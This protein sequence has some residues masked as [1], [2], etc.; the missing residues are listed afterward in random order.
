MIELTF[1]GAMGCVG[2]SAVLVDTGNEKLM[3]DYGV[4]VSERPHVFPLPVEG[5]VD[6]ILLTHS[7]LDHS[8]ALPILSRNGVPIY[9]LKVNKP[10]A[11]LLLNDSIKVSHEEGISLPFD[12][13]DVVTTINNFKQVEYKKEL[14]IHKTRINF[15]DAGHIPGS[16]MIYLE[17]EK[18]ILYTGD[19]NTLETR[20][21]KACEKK[22]PET[23][24]LITECTY[25]D[26]DHPNRKRQEKELL[27]LVDATLAKDGIALI[28]AFA[29]ARA[30]EILL[31]LNSKG[32]DYPCYLDGMAKKATTILIKNKACKD[33]EK[34][35]EAL[36]NVK[37]INTAKQRKK[38]IK[39][40]GVIVTTSGMLHG[41]PI[42]WY[43]KRLYKKE[44]CSLILTGFQVE[45][46]PGKTLLETGRFIYDSLDL[47]VKMLVR[48]F[49]FSAHVG[50]SDLI[51]FI[52]RINPEK[53]FC[54]HGD[55][56]E[57]FAFELKEMGFDAV[58]PLA[59]NRR[60][61]I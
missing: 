61:K 51:K 25:S 37:Y 36:E 12:K 28:A 52:K 26:R 56:T 54:V 45:G 14:K 60:F 1:L 50:R 46:T 35:D 47:E 11:E 33:C 18:K 19:F 53:V 38:A 16:A 3:L 7:H 42:V 31:V 41:G 43:L 9:S 29:I 20:L 34:L 58:A 59:N 32:I 22:L 57:E 15:L 10:L 8:G 21:V 27:K 48:K 4:K 13:N 44:N 23:D 5:K 17:N 24:V 55:H 2:A 49:D 39:Q 40:P 6:A 30:Q